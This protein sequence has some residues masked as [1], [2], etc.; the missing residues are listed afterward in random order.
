MTL[1]R[2]LSDYER[3]RP[4]NP[5]SAEGIKRLRVL[6]KKQNLRCEL[7]AGALVLRAR[8][9]VQPAPHTPTSAAFVLF[10]GGRPWGSLRGLGPSRGGAACG[11][12]ALT[13]P[14]GKPCS[15]QSAVRKA[16]ENR[17]TLVSQRSSAAGAGARP[18]DPGARGAPSVSRSTVP[19]DQNRAAAP[20]EWEAGAAS[21]E[22]DPPEHTPDLRRAGTARGHRRQQR[23]QFRRGR[24]EALVPTTRTS[25]PQASRA[26]RGASL[27]A[28]RFR[29][30]AST[31]ARGS[32]RPP[33]P[34]VALRGG[35]T[36]AAPR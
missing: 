21:H 4:P 27:P 19:R 6:R 26:E 34:A 24:R 23:A 13:G 35:G 30:A 16:S 18:R 31:S 2:R 15:R 10:P 33:G 17:T 32:A 25:G 22:R 14:K 29:P 7:R 20:R 1:L 28:R 3:L 5:R 9:A 12:L 11:H 8:R 36:M